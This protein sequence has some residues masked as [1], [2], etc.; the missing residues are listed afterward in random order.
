[1]ADQFPASDNSV[2]LEA[3][4]LNPARKFT[5]VELSVRGNGNPLLI[6]SK[7]N[8]IRYLHSTWWSCKFSIASR[9]ADDSLDSRILVEERD[10]FGGLR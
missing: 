8:S 2:G 9:K 5:V 3:I 1:M 4:V 10:I 7:G 6:G